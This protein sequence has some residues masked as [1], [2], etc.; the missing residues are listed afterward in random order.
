MKQK[1]TKALIV[2]AHPD[3]AEICCF[4]TICKISKQVDEIKLLIVTGGE[5]GVSVKTIPSAAAFPLAYLPTKRLEETQKAFSQIEMDIRCLGYQDGNLRVSGDIISQI[6]LEFSDFQPDIVITHFVD[7]SGGDHQDHEVVGKIVTNVCRR[8][9]SVTLLLHAQPHNMGIS[10]P[11]N[12]FVEVSEFV[13]DRV[14]AL[15][16]HDTQAGRYY[17]SHIYHDAR[18]II[19]SVASGNCGPECDVHYEAFFASK[20]IA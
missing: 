13:S 7:T 20:I 11:A 9:K 12:Y 5:K 14:V 8:A 3:D 10:F 6:E 2:M 18:G 17:L 15:N 1:V 19:N 16:C 4:G